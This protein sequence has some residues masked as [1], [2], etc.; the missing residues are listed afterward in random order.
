MSSSTTT[1]LSRQP[2]TQVL[3]NMA[4]PRDRRGVRYDLPT[5]LS[6]AVTGVLAGCRSLE[7]DAPIVCQAPAFVEAGLAGCGGGW[8]WLFLAVSV[9]GPGG[10]VLGGGAHADGGMGPDGA[11]TSGP[12]RRWRP[13]AASMSSQGPWLRMSPGLVQGA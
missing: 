1:A 7:P 3:R 9:G 4:D 8:L 11:R 6:L 2:L 5:I 13:R 10:F 12:T